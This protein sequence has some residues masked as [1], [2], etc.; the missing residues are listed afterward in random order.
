MNDTKQ[1][2]K[3]ITLRAQG[4]ALTTIAALLGV[5]RQTLA[6]WEEDLEEEIQNLK[7]IELDALRETYF[8]TKQARIEEIAA[9]RRRIREELDKRDFSGVPTTKLLQLDLA[10]QAKLESEFG[11]IRPASE[12]A[13]IKQKESK[14]VFCP[15]VS[16]ASSSSEAPA[17]LLDS[18]EPGN[19]KRR[20]EQMK[21]H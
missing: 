15:P 21:A 19:G 2:L 12:R 5:S 17:L 1:K 4:K 3:F 7:A 13:L 20:R 9:L 16:K 8:M 14:E 10:Y 11:N 6:N 18:T